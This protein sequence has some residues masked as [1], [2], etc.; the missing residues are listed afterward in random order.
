MKQTIVYMGTGDRVNSLSLD[1]SRL[2]DFI[3]GAWR[4]TAMYRSVT[5]SVYWVILG[6]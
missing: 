6:N 4:R 3:P 5:V 2:V 1:I